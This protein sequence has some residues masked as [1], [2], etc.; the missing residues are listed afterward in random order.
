MPTA[1]DH[2]GTGRTFV[3]FCCAF[4]PHFLCP[5]ALLQ[6]GSQAGNPA[7]AAG[8]S[9]DCRADPPV[10][11]GRGFEMHPPADSVLRPGL[12]RLSRVYGRL[13]LRFSREQISDPDHSLGPVFYGNAAFQIHAGLPGAPADGEG[14]R[15][16][17]RGLHRTLPVFRETGVPAGRAGVYRLLPVFCHGRV[18]YQPFRGRGHDQPLRQLHLRQ[19]PG[20]CQHVQNHPGKP[21][22]RALP[23]RSGGQDSFLSGNAAAPGISA[24]DDE[25]VAAPDAAHPLCADQPD[26]QL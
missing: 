19:A 25:T 23:D 6:A 7:G 13:F 26:V 9:G 22:L 14:G 17:V 3:P 18:V 10:P 24:P 4:V 21:G 15:A 1:P 20:A 2:R 5:A 16:R 8:P 11:F 12:L